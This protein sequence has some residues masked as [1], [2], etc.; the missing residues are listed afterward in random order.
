[1]RPRASGLASAC[2]LAVLLSVAAGS[3]AS[4][5]WKEYQYADLGIAKEFPAEPKAALSTYKTQVAGT[6][7]AHVFTVDQDGVTYSLIVV[8]LMDKADRGS[9]IQGECVAMAEDEGK[10]VANM[11]ARVEFAAD[12]VYGRIVSADLKNGSRAMTECFYTKGRLYK[13]VATIAPANADY[14]NSSEA[15]RFINTLSFK[16]GADKA[17][18][19][20]ADAKGPRP[21]GY[22]ALGGRAGQTAGGLVDP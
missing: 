7:P 12:A 17:P 1:M 6:A 3:P 4:A 16:F 9:S 22:D 10:P 19:A 21:G 14:P 18:A 8:D 11:Q 2:S 5:A 15:I 20:G 13:I